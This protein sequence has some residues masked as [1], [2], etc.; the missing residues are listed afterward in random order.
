MTDPAPLRAALWMGGTIVSFTVMALA[1]RAAQLDLPTFELMLYRSILGCMLI[2]MIAVATGRTQE[3]RTARP[4]THLI[5]NLFHFSGQNLWFYALTVLPLAQVFALEFTAPIWVALLAPLVL[6]ERLSPHRVL[7]A[8]LGFAGI[9]LV[10]RPDP[11]A[12]ELGSIAAALAAL[13][14]AATNIATKKLT[15]TDSVLR[16][17]FWLTLMQIGMGFVGAAWDGQITLPRGIGWLWVGLIAVCGLSAHLSL[18]SALSLAPASFVMPID[19][20]RLPVI[21]LIGASFYSEPI[22]LWLLAGG[23]LIVL[24]N[25]WNLHKETRPRRPNGV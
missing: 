1:G 11:M 2:T 23:T 13:C 21:A 14:F 9:L 8:A 25:F 24:A 19:F 12:L 6:G 16:I 17:L 4:G 10:T 20:L 7:A 5:R 3:L 18:T 15:R 22:D